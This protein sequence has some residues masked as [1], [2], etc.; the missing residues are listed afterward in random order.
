LVVVLIVDELID[1]NGS[2]LPTSVVV[3]EVPLLVLPGLLVTNDDNI[4]EVPTA[5]VDE[6]I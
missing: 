6:V 3:V 2:V 4:S 5:I 1:V